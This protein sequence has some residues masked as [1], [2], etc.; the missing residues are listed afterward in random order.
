V[1]ALAFAIPAVRAASHADPAERVLPAPAIRRPEARRQYASGAALQALYLSPY[2]GVIALAFLTDDVPELE[3][4]MGFAVVPLL[5][6]L[7]LLLAWPA[8]VALAVEHESPLPALSPA[9]LAATAERMGDGYGAC[10]ALVLLGGA[11]VFFG[12]NAL[13]EQGVL[14]RAADSLLLAWFWLTC[15]YAVGRSLSRLRHR[16]APP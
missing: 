10:A 14:G 6:Q 8:A 5:F 15:T 2:L 11:A 3:W 4:T 12:G 7:V 16:N 13:R 9:R 1:A